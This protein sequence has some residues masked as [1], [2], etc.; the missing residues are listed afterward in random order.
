MAKKELWFEIHEILIR[1]WDPIGVRY[2]DSAHD[3]YDSFISEIIRM[4]EKGA[5]KTKLTDHLF[6]L[7][8]IGSSVYRM[9]KA[10]IAA[11]MILESFKRT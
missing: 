3:E 2:F 5:D 11:Q 10:E 7:A 9:Q 4:L 1:E 8:V 6:Q